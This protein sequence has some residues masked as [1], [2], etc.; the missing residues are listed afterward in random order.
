[1]VDVQH[2]PLRAF[3][4]HV[5]ACVAIA[6]QQFGHIAEHG[7]ELLA[8]G[9]RVVQGFLVIQRLGMV[10]MGEDEVM[11]VQQCLQPL[12]KTGGVQQIARPQARRETLSS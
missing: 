12:G 9:Q 8:Q 10:I 6:I 1:M 4:Q 11:I 2:R 5:L 7:F 3:K